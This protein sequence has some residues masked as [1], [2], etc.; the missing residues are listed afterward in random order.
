MSKKIILILITLFGIVLIIG[1][2]YF[3]MKY[4]EKKE[5]E[6]QYYDVQKGRIELFMKHNVKGYKTIHFSEM[7]R[8]PMDGYDI[9]GYINNDKESSF[10]AGIRSVENF[11]FEGDITS[12]AK[13]EKMYKKNTKS[14][15]QI[16]KEKSKKEEK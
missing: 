5:K 11:K 4:D 7:K 1:G 6:Q 16:K 15:S 10:T 14:V 8:N 2:I 12:S 3:K 13:L 9:S